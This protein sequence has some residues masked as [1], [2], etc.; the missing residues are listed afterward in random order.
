MSLAPSLL[1]ALTACGDK[2]PTTDTDRRT[3][4]SDA[5]HVD[6]ADTGSPGDTAPA[7]SCTVLGTEP[8]TLALDAAT[9]LQV[10]LECDELEAAA[11]AGWQL[12]VDGVTYPETSGTIRGGDLLVLDAASVTLSSG[13][14]VVVFDLDD[15]QDTL[16]GT[17]RAHHF[18]DDW[19]G[20]T[21]YLKNSDPVEGGDLHWPQ[22]V[23]TDGD[24]QLEVIGLGEA[25]D[26]MDLVLTGPG[27]VVAQQTIVDDENN[28][29][30]GSGIFK[31]N[32][33]EATAG[34]S[35]LGYIVWSGSDVREGVSLVV[36]PVT[37]SSAGL[38][39]TVTLQ[40][41]PDYDTYGLTPT[42]VLDVAVTGYDE[43]DDGP[44]VD[45]VVLGEATAKTGEAVW[46]WTDSTTGRIKSV[47][48]FGHLV[49]GDDVHVS[50]LRG[51]KDSTD[52]FDPANADQLGLFVAGPNKDGT[53]TSL[54][55]YDP[56]TGETTTLYEGSFPGSDSGG[57][58]SAET[59]GDVDGDGY[60]ELVVHIDGGFVG[61][62]P[63]LDDRRFGQP[64]WVVFDDDGTAG[65]QALHRNPAIWLYPRTTRLHV[66]SGSHRLIEWVDVSTA[67][68]RDTR[69]LV[70]G[71]PLDDLD[72]DGGVLVIDEVQ[73]L[74][75]PGTS[76]S[77]EGGASRRATP[78]VVGGGD[79]EPPEDASSAL[80]EGDLVLLGRGTLGGSTLLT[81][82]WRPD[83]EAVE[84]TV[85]ARIADGEDL[86]LSTSG[87]VDLG[88]TTL[89]LL[90]AEALMVGEGGLARKGDV[91]LIRKPVSET[92]DAVP[93]LVL[94]G[95]EVVGSTS[96]TN[97][98]GAEL[99]DWASVDNP[100]GV[101]LL[102]GPDPDTLHLVTLGADGGPV[103][104]AVPV[105]TLLESAKSGAPDAAVV[106]SAD[107]LVELFDSA[108]ASV[109]PPPSPGIVSTA[110]DATGYHPTLGE[111][112]ALPGQDFS[113]EVLAAVVPY[114]TGTACP[115]ATVLLVGD[116]LD[117]AA[118]SP[119]VLATSDQ[120]DCADLEVP[121]LSA[122]VLGTGTSQLITA[123]T[124]GADTVLQVYGG[125][126]STL[127]A[128][129]ELRLEGVD[130]L[131]TLTD[132]SCGSSYQANAD[133]SFLSAGDVDGNGLDD[134]Y[135][136]LP[137]ADGGVLW[138]SDGLRFSDWAEPEEV[139]FGAVQQGFVG[140]SPSAAT[141]SDGQ[142][143]T[144]PAPMRV[145]LA[146]VR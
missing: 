112:D 63:A 38:G 115:W 123:R 109:S 83:G 133:C 136:D 88:G 18:I 10:V 94:E 30:G 13:S 6:T 1:L 91:T 11:G 69:S 104:A 113:R 20:E 9:D 89:D 121:V 19:Q 54:F 130:G 3:D 33:L 81:R 78:M 17:V 41:T 141:P 50:F 128:S 85:I 93:L 125:D 72:P 103:L 73:V 37:T 57:E 21:A 86:S 143:G 45:V 61:I 16:S 51:V 108:A 26:G 34:P 27:G 35:K 7:Y 110:L 132:Q 131:G 5:V 96:I 106:P 47:A 135:I 52:R 90:P 102:A 48:A 126:G 138:R 62:V 36:T 28:I 146:E 144:E 129:D 120:E 60:S 137:V 42:A 67:T 80:G 145:G 2:D 32:E 15:G 99:A 70:V 79:V 140:V 119:V 22:C 46:T 84:P 31:N 71:A 40:V 101:Q 100:H 87:T 95:G 92:G 4:D 64:T 12:T 111:L 127:L 122:D 44:K 142:G 116:D 105:D 23:D 77:A 24:G 75:A 39:D 49:P 82:P 98:F 43:A 107:G 55:R 53:G 76:V 65:P 25:D 58:V 8:A 66:R 59:F 74:G 124:D 134:L 97:D 117:D 118:G 29:R 14:G 56:N 114:E 139:P 68:P